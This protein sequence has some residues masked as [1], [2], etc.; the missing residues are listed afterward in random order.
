[1]V[2]IEAL[3]NLA[4]VMLIAP[5]LDGFARKVRARIQCRMGPPIL[6]TWYDIIKL[7]KKR[8][9]D[10]EI[11]GK[12]YSISPYLSLAFSLIAVLIIPIGCREPPLSFTGDVLLLI[13]L[14]AS[15]SLLMAF[16]STASGN[17]FS[18]IG[19]SRMLSMMILG[20]GMLAGSIITFSVFSGSLRIGSVIKIL[21]TSPHLATTVALIPLA[22]FVYLESE[23][24]PL[25]IHEAEPEIIGL[26]VEF[27]GRKLGLMRYSLMIR[28]TVLATLLIYLAFPWWLADSY[29]SPFYPISIILWLLLLFLLTFIFTVL[30]S[31][32]ARYRINNAIESLVPFICISFLSIVLAFLGV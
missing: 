22:V 31:S 25:D 27:S 11:S 26:L 5:I 17:P 1:M 21:S 30:D 18:G 13:Y 24:V 10:P 23:R 4:L 7:F 15:S 14:L 32:L 16:G 3:I 29:I 19:A 20:E 8:D 12:L 6:Q 9:I 28:S 2:L